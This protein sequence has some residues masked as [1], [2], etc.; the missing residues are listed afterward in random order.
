MWVFVCVFAELDKICWWFKA[1]IYTPIPPSAPSPFNAPHLHLPICLSS[2]SLHP[3]SFSSSLLCCPPF[4]CH[5]PLYFFL[6]PVLYLLPLSF[7]LIS[8]AVCLKWCDPH[9][10]YPAT[11]TTTKKITLERCLNSSRHMLCNQALTMHSAARTHTHTHH[12][13]RAGR[14]MWR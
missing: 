13:E 14:R 3:L 9:A 6:V 1:N 2:F 4:T 11:E 7:H 8:P 5:P 10:S 12:W